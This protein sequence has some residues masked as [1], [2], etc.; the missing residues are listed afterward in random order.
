MQILRS[1]FTLTLLGALQGLPAAL[2]QEFGG[3]PPGE[4]RME[5]FAWCSSCHSARIIIQQGLTR[6]D[7]DE[8]LVW[9]VE[10]Q[11]MLEPDPVMRERILDYLAEQFPPERPHF[12]GN[13]GIKPNL[14]KLMEQN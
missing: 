8:M 11:D 13:T 12:M 1:I 5:V 6:E 9:M 7:W 4:G 14:N 10:E 2:A 3:L